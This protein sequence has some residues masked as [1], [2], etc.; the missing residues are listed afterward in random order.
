MSTDIL[1]L[2]TAVADFRGSEFTFTDKL[3][4]PGG[5]AKCDTKDMPDY[6]QRQYKARIDKG[7]V[8]VGGAGN[9][10][11]LIAKAGLKVAVGVNLGKGDFDGLDAQGRFFYDMMTKNNVDMSQTYIHPELPTGTTFIGGKVIDLAGAGDSFRAGLI[12]YVT[13]NL[14]AFKDGV[15]DFEEA[16][17]IANLF[18]S[19]YIQAPLNARYINIARYP[20][21]LRAV[22]K[23]KY[24]NVSD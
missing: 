17:Q 24:D 14:D 7:L 16:I 19:L 1:I 23:A 6:G 13:N 21:M 4:G 10:A 12:C 18:A 20:E 9:V 3:V 15:I 11:P 5:L 22:K 8:T 2:N